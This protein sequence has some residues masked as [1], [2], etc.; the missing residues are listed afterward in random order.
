MI[1]RR[2][3]EFDVKSCSRMG[4]TF[5]KTRLKERSSLKSIEGLF[6]PGQG[7]QPNII[8]SDSADK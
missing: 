8:I 3:C 6:M 1:E 5:M 2:C 7:I 4:N